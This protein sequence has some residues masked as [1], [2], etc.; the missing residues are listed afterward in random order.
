[1]L[2]WLL[3]NHFRTQFGRWGSGPL[4]A[5][6]AGFDDERG[7]GQTPESGRLTTGTTWKSARSSRRSMRHRT[8]PRCRRL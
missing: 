2:G 5:P 1:V 4:Q 7:V 8:Y 6:A 3:G